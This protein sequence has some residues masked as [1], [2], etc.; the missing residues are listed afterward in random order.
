MPYASLS[1]N[2]YPAV[3]WREPSMTVEE[4]LGDE[5][6]SG[7]RPDSALEQSI[8]T[9]LDLGIEHI[10]SEAYLHFIAVCASESDDY[11]LVDLRKSKQGDF[12]SAQ[13]PVQETTCSPKEVPDY[14]DPM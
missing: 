13:L 3:V 10:S 9:Q 6:G 7:Y 5:L 4:K 2:G 8:P 12:H 14:L 1:L 11:D